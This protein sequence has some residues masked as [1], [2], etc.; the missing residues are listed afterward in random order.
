MPPRAGCQG[1]WEGSGP[2]QACSWWPGVSSPFVHCPPCC[3]APVPTP[4]GQGPWEQVQ[5]SKAVPGYS[6]ASATQVC[7]PFQAV[8][9]VRRWNVSGKAEGG[10][11]WWGGR[12]HV[13]SSLPA[14]SV[15]GPAAPWATAAAFTPPVR[16]LTQGH[17]PR[18]EGVDLGTRVCRVLQNSWAAGPLRLPGMRFWGRG[19]GLQVPTPGGPEQRQILCPWE[20]KG[21]RDGGPS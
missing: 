3:S 16:L 12:G 1:L 18:A 2:G 13:V 17:L 6:L 19:G 21:G 15:A 20:G 14:S 11:P 10:W 7:F 4:G 5:G 8:R 9:G